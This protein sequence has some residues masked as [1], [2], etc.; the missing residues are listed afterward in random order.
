MEVVTAKVHPEDG[1]IIQAASRLRGQS[2]SAYV[3][4]TVVPAAR[5]TVAQALSDSKSADGEEK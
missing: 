4:D 2:V 3:R 5:E 1:T